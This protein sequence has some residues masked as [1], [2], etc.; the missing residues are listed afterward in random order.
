MKTKK[1]IL[2]ISL[3]FLTSCFTGCTTKS[4]YEGVQIGAKQ[5]CNNK[6]LRE[7]EECLKN[8]NKK[9]MKSMKNAK[10]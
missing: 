6:P 2:L 10:R 8:L 3:A 9:H 1:T 5:N 7:R 4:Y